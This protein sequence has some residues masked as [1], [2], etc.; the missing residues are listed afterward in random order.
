MYIDVNS[1]DSYDQIR[2]PIED[3]EL[4]LYGDV[5]THIPFLLNFLKKLPNSIETLRLGIRLGR[6]STE[7]AA[8]ILA[9]I[10]WVKTLDLSNNELFIKQSP[11]LAK[12]LS[13]IPNSV[14][15]LDLDRNRLEDKSHGYMAEVFAAIPASV[16]QIGYNN[17]GEFCD[18]SVLDEKFPKPI[19]KSNATFYL[20]C[21]CG[22]SMIA[23]SSLLVSALLVMSLPLMAVGAGLLMA[24]VFGAVLNRNGFFTKSSPIAV[25][26]SPTGTLDTIVRA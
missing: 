23:G 1:S 15:W 13:N 8:S 5:S 26:P 19:P 20:N 7:Q 12:I 17:S 16:T 6:L 3:S 11:E 25:A 18:R 4:E 21:L 2:F 10:P 14:I 22:I 24:G 9:H